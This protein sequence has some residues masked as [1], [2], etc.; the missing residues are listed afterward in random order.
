MVT[1]LLYTART[2]LS[3][4]N[5]GIV[6]PRAISVPLRTSY[7]MNNSLPSLPSQE[8]SR[9]LTWVS[10]KQGSNKSVLKLIAGWSAW[11]LWNLGSI[12]RV[13]EDMTF[14]L[15]SRLEFVKMG[16]SSVCYVAVDHLLSGPAS[17]LVHSRLED[18]VHPLSR[19]SPL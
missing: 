9:S 6:F 18:H 5:T 16:H 8:P 14:Q 1:V 19:P 15:S 17:R 12:L 3:R 11:L 13:P 7:P 2:N 4:P 10:G